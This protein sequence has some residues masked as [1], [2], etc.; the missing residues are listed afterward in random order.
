MTLLRYCSFYFYFRKNVRLFILVHLLRLC[1]NS[2][3]FGDCSPESYIFFCVW[4]WRHDHTLRESQERWTTS[5][6]KNIILAACLLIV[7]AISVALYIF[8]CFAVVLPEDIQIRFFE[9][10][11]E[12][13]VVWETY[14]D[15]SDLDVHHQV[16]NVELLLST[17]FHSFKN[18]HKSANIVCK[19]S[20]ALLP[21]LTMVVGGV[22]Q[23]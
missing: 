12:G 13:D 17:I 15:L 9:Q 19:V 11:P 7:S 22:A 23:W 3:R 4:R 10:S 2:S 14:P 21:L 16:K 1:R 18:T 6:H 8:G 5:V 20:L